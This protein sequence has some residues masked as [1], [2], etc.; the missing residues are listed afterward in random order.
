MEEK[1]NYIMPDE[2]TFY[3]SD[4]GL[5]MAKYK[6]VDMGRVA[7][8][9]MFPLQYSEEYLC[10]RQE[11]YERIDKDNEIGIIRTLADFSGEQT[12]LVR[13]ELERRYF[14][15]DIVSVTDISEEVGHILWKV[16]TTKGEREFTLTDMSS[17]ILNLGGGRILLTDVYG[18][19]Y[20]IPNITKLDDKTMQV[21]EIWI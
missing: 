17:N 19:R 7:V 5:L 12:A 18:N 10:V 3:K 1:L 2:I 9:R 8:L 20:R 6:N 4:G 14:V 21:I 13:A 16:I 11:N 15:P